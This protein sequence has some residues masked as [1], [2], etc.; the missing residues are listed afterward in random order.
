MKKVRNEENDICNDDVV[1]NLDDAKTADCDAE[2][3]AH[4][5][6]SLTLW[7]VIISERVLLFSKVVAVEIEHKFIQDF[8]THEF[9]KQKQ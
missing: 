9:W 5:K 7:R 6:M 1:Y 2:I 8:P 3:E 4:S